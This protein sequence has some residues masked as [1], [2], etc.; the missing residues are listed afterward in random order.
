MS[1]WA[2]GI[3]LSLPHG[4]C[5]Q[6]WC[7]RRYRPAPG[8]LVGADAHIGPPAAVCNALRRPHAPKASPWC[9]R[10]GGAKRRRG[11]EPAETGADNPSVTLRVTAPFTQGSLPSQ[12]SGLVAF[13]DGAYDVGTERADVGI[14]PYGVHSAT[15]HPTRRC[16]WADIKSA[17]TA[18]L[19]YTSPMSKQKIV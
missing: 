7:V 18:P 13:G 12:A 11:S 4:G 17:P 10:G 9:P 2:H 8:L 3:V 19:C 15:V 5:V 6:R 16:P 14:G 1:I